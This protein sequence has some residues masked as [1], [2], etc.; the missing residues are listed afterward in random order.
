MFIN[1]KIIFQYLILVVRLNNLQIRDN[2]YEQNNFING[3]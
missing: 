1:K 3:T 2:N